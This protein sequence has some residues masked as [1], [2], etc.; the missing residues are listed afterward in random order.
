[1]RLKINH[2]LRINPKCPTGKWPLSL[3]E[4][5][6]SE[7]S[8]HSLP[9]VFISPPQNVM[10]GWQSM[11]WVYVVLLHKLTDSREPLSQREFTV[12]VFAD[13]VC[14]QAPSQFAK[15]RFPGEKAKNRRGRSIADQCTGMS[16]TCPKCE[17]LPVRRNPS[18]ESRRFPRCQSD[19][20][21]I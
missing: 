11:S 5:Q 19:I 20:K 16:N 21:A 3:V 14:R 9:I 17:D 13:R 18:Q 8:C 2:L 4:G 10:K 1:M 6:M 12:I 7:K 15:S